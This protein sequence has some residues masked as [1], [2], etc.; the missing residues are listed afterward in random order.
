MR[1]LSLYIGSQFKKPRG[2]FGKCCCI[3][4]NVINN[5]MYRRVLQYIDA[6]EKTKI[7]DIGYGNG[8][9]INRIYKKYSSII[10]GIDISEDMKKEAE[11]RNEQG[12]KNGN[13]K[14]SVGDCC[15]CV[16][17][18]N[19]FD[20]ITTVNTVY[21]WQSSEVG[22]AEMYRILKPNGVFYN[23]VY[24]KEWL[25]RLSYTKEGFHFF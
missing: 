19:F 6:D 23:V 17:S 2:F 25:Q 16:Y 11:K 4:M 15:N 7:L 20:I 22:L 1:K 3:V 18:D 21:F 8:Y 10:Y 14:L 13:I 9:L 24:T 5:A 12:V